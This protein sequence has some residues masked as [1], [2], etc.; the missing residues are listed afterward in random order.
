M[1]RP[2]VPVPQLAAGSAAGQ[3]LVFNGTA[4]VKG[5]L[6]FNGFGGHNG[7]GACTMT[8]AKVGDVVQSVLSFGAG[9]AAD[10]ETVITVNDQIQQTVAVDLHTGSFA[11]LLIRAGS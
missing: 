10:F 8:G 3:I 6:H 11:A 9:S 2:P 7:I 1:K 4:W 5:S